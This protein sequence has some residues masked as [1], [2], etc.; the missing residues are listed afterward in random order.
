MQDMSVA[1]RIFAR[2]RAAQRGYGRHSLGRKRTETVIAATS[3]R[4]GSGMTTFPVVA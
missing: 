3:A 4:L 2:V 1:T